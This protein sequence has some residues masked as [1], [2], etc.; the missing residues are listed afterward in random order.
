V[1]IELFRSLDS[2]FKQV[3]VE[4]F[5]SLVKALECTF[6]TCNELVRVASFA[7]IDGNR[8]GLKAIASI[9]VEA[10]GTSDL[11]CIEHSLL[12]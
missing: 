1:K 3:C 10:M 8:L 7:T 6:I 5:N 11:A 12:D 2:S 9:C 4:A